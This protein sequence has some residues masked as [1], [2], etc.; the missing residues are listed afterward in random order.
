VLYLNDGVTLEERFSGVLGSDLIVA[1]FG[2][3]TSHTEVQA[4]SS[5]INQLYS[6]AAYLMPIAGGVL[7]D[8][9]LGAKATLVLG[10]VLMAAGQS[11]PTRAGN[12]HTRTHTTT[13]ARHHAP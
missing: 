10:G 4:L 7:A 13:S 5:N 2:Q 1:W 8:A 11:V 3:P 12:D 9:V 6:G